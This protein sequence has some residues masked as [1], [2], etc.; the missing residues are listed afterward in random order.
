MKER[1]VH[2]DMLTGKAVTV[3]NNPVS[4][5]TSPDSKLKRRTPDN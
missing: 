2:R 4:I 5:V 3:K 1:R